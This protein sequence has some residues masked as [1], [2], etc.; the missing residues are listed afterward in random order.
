MEEMRM[1]EPVVIVGAELGEEHERPDPIK[2]SGHL[3]MV[4]WKH[5][6]EAC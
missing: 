1:K 3:L 6:A 5:Y 2:G 4:T